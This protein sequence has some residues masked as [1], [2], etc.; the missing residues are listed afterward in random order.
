MVGSV[1]VM[2]LFFFFNTLKL[3]QRVLIL[4]GS[5]NANHSLSAEYCPLCWSAKRLVWIWRTGLQVLLKLLVVGLVD[6]KSKR[7]NKAKLKEETKEG[8]A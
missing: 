7:S 2:I 3:L 6:Q 5:A 8:I 1:E 4:F